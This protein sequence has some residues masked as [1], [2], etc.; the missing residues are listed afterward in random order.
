MRNHKLLTNLPG[1]LEHAVKSRFSKE[2]TLDKISATLQE[3]RIKT[4]IGRYN[5][6]S[7]GDNR[8]NPTLED[9]ETHDSEYEITTG[10]HNCES[11]NHYADNF[12][13]DREEIF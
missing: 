3:V 13:K 2:S 7:I 8:E 1:D 6:H 10:S 4:F 5:N 11:P 12:P 9:K